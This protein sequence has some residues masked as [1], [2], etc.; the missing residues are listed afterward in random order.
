MGAVTISAL[1]ILYA[2][3]TGT[4]TG[5]LNCECPCAK[6]RGNLRVPLAFVDAVSVM[7]FPFHSSAAT[8][9]CHLAKSR[10]VS[11]PSGGRV[12]QTTLPSSVRRFSC[13]H[14]KAAAFKKPDVSVLCLQP[15]TLIF[16]ESV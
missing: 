5:D 8:R 14:Q 10:S 3:M 12:W 9:E 2:L 16:V 15:E 4:E 6:P 7:F 1:R 13:L 11:R